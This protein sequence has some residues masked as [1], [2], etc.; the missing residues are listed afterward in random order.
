M[1]S[2]RRAGSFTAPASSTHDN[3]ARGH[4]RD[5]ESAAV[6]DHDVVGAR[7]EHVRRELLRLRE[8]LLAG[9][10][11][12]AAADLERARST[13]SAAAQHLGGVGVHDADVVHGDAERVADDHGERRLV[14][15]AV[16]AG[17]DARRHRAVVFDLDRA[18]LAVERE[19]RADL[20]VRRDA[21][22]EQL[23]V[24]ALAALGLLDEQLRVAGLV[25]GDVE[26]LRVLAA[27]VGRAQAGDRRGTGTPRAG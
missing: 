1:P 24:A 19:R 18:V 23:R 12:R 7:L 11:Q 6:A 15:L 26:R 17:A 22:A 20:E 13:G 10:E 3:A 5:L 21:D 8:H 2:G 16:R 27:V 4:A 25:D 14:A 9:T